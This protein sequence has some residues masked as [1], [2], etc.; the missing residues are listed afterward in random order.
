MPLSATT[1]YDELDSNIDNVNTEA[2][3]ILGWATVFDNYF[4]EALAVITP[5]ATG[6]AVTVSMVNSGVSS[7]I[8][9]VFPSIKSILTLNTLVNCLIFP[10]FS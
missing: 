1:L 9:S 3:A 5:P 10:F 2:E 8:F 7:G 6:I 4:Q